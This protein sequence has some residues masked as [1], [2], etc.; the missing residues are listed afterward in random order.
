MKTSETPGPDPLAERLD[1]YVEALLRGDPEEVR[2]F[3]TRDARVLLPG[4]VLDGEGLTDFVEGFYGGDGRV[5]SAAFERADLFVHGD[6]AYEL[7]RYDET[8][9]V[10]G[11]TETVS[12][13]Y[14]LRWERSE[15]GTWR[16]DRFVGGPVEAPIPEE[17]G[18]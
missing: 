16:I 1:A 10:A 15:D 4:L 2:G 14:F 12:G 9:E 8:A 18:G 6:A 17:P 5:T 11:E 7:G 13:H 3:W